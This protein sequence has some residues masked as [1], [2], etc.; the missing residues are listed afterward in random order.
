MSVNDPFKIVVGNFVGDAFYMRSIAGFMLEG[1]FKAAGLSSIAR[2][3]DENEPFSF[4]ID[5]KNDST[6]PD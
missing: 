5:K 1:R 2:L 3:I 4:I 6:C